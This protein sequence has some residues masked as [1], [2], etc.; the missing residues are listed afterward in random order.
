M[1]NSELISCRIDW[2]NLVTEQQQK[3]T[4]EGTELGQASELG[5]EG[6]SG[7]QGRSWE[8]VSGYSHKGEEVEPEAKL[9]NS[10]AK[11][12]TAFHWCYLSGKGIR[13][14]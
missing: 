5:Q 10:G 11:G 7:R 9:R 1:N 6:G 8:G 14:F 13:A 2:F 12:W 4:L 3:D